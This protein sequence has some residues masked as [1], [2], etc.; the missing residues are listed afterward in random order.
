M[1]RFKKILATS[2]FSLSLSACGGGGGGGSAVNV[3]SNFIEQDLTNL[4]GSELII[5]DYTNLISNFQNIISNGEYSSLSAVITGP[6]SEDIKKANDLLSILNQTEQL[7]LQTE[8]LINQQSDNEKYNIYNSKSYKEAYA[9]YLYLINDVEPIIEKVSKG[10]S[11]TLA[12]YNKVAQKEKADEIIKTEKLLNAEQVVSKKVIKETLIIEENRQETREYS[13]DPEISYTSWSPIF[14]GGGE[15]NRTKSTKIKNF[16]ETTNFKC[17]FKRINY[18]NGNK[19]DEEPVC[20]K[21]NSNI[22]ELKPIIT[23]EIEKK[24]GDNPIV[25]TV[26]LEPLTDKTIEESETY[27]ETTFKDSLELIEEITEGSG[28]TKTISRDTTFRK[29]LEDN[30]AIVTIKRFVDTITT[31]PVTKKIFK[32]R[33]YTDLIKKRQRQVLV[34]I[35]R[36][37]NFYKDGSD[38]IIEN[39]KE[40]TYGDWVEKFLKTENRSENI[41]VDS[42]TSEKISTVTDEGTIISEQLISNEYT[43]NDIN[44][45]QKTVGLSPNIDDHKTYE[46]KSN[47]GLD[48]IN[49]ASAYSKGWTGKGAILGVIDTYQDIN[50]KEFGD[51]YLYFK[52]YDLYRDTLKITQ[53]HGSHVAGIMAA[54][55]DGDVFDDEG[56]LITGVYNGD[57]L[58]RNNNVHGVAYDA[59]LVGA[60]V[61]RFSNGFIS[62][63]QAQNALKDFAK[64]KSPKSEGGEELN[65]VAVNMSFN[66]RHLFL[67]REGKTTTKLSDGTFKAEELVS[68]MRFDGQYINDTGSSKYYKTATDNDIILVNSAGNYGF[69]HAGDPG[70]WATEVDDNGKLILGGKMVIVGDWNGVGVSGNKAGHVCLDINTSDNTCNDKHRI[71]DFY[72]L[73]PGTNIYSSITND[74]YVSLS[75]TS[76]SAPH[77]TGAFGVL[78]QMWPYMKGDN[79]VKLVMNTAN[80][81]LPNYNV[82]IHGQGLL[83]LD[84]ATNPQG[85]LGIPTT[86]R[87]DHPTINLQNTY[88]STGTAL[89]SNLDNLKIMILDDYD[90]NYYLEIG[91]SFTVQDKRK[92][93]DIKMISEKNNYFLPLNQMYGSFSQGG[94]YTLDQNYN[95]GFYTNENGNGDYSLNVGKDFFPRDDIKI[96]TSISHLSEQNTWLGNSSDGALG[97]GKNNISNSGNIGFDYLLGNNIVSFDYSL[98]KTK[99][100]TKS[101]SLIKSFSD[102]NTNSY[103]LAYKINKD[104]NNSYGWSFSVPNYIKSGEMNLE[105]AESVNLDGSIN[106]KNLTSDLSSNTIEKNFGFF[107]NKKGEDTFDPSFNFTAEYRQDISGKRDNDGLNLNISFTKKVNFSCKLLWFKNPKCFDENGKLKNIN[108][109]KNPV[110]KYGLVYNLKTDKFEPINSDKK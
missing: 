67:D 11:V 3:I 33:H 22:S 85:A 77:V 98:G 7:W 48:I 15:E 92:Y 52:N 32:T 110:E 80:K 107:Y 19:V 73:A 51:K 27:T 93:S 79:L 6:N 2:I 68:K 103:R 38:E 42:Q 56:K 14:K 76:M 1:N 28:I 87:V 9:A 83:D 84:E 102:L 74:E 94:Q 99:I 64:L 106:Y 47:R 78:N 46:Y 17:S 95:L 18:L 37:K 10:K 43:G 36:E 12:D 90:R 45:G 65:I 40:T 8:D 44:L 105:L 54:N 39:D 100:N 13:S 66:S 91:S 86:G 81:D 89:P 58:L 55:K 25:K 57:Q 88:F 53:G 96:K 16:K 104:I 35:K 50:H 21:I 63:G 20:K 97:V 23:E 69:E 5:S 41:L 59:K 62:Q 72:I 71:S 70:I 61:D 30:K 109:K 26:S 31:I 29:N 34:E 60:N 101:N 24:A 49:A 4:N 82:N 75:G 108:F